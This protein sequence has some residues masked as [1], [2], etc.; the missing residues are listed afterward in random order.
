[1]LS[2]D[3][4]PD[5]RHDCGQ[6]TI[7]I[8]M[9][10]VVAAA[11]IMVAVDASIVFLGRQRLASAADGAAVRAA[12]QFDQG[13]YY[14]G[15]CVNSLPL[16]IPAANAAVQ[17]FAKD[18]IQLRAVPPEGGGTGVDIIGQLVVDLPNV[19]VIGLTSYTVNY[20]TNARSSLSGA[21]C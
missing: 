6:I 4:A 16:D 8:V 7:L 18:G 20:R 12:Q 10:S 19:P 3:D 21:P 9:F 14:S 17:P 13:T 5:Q 11:V 2:D 15:E 1:M